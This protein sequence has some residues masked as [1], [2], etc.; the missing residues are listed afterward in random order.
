MWRY[1]LRRWRIVKNQKLHDKLTIMKKFFTIFLKAESRP[2]LNMLPK[3]CERIFGEAPGGVVILDG[4]VLKKVL[5]RQF[6]CRPKMGLAANKDKLRKLTESICSPEKM[7][8]LDMPVYNFALEDDGYSADHIVIADGRHRTYLLIFEHDVEFLPII[9][10]LAFLPK[11][12]NL[13]GYKYGYRTRVHHQKQEV[14]DVFQ[15][16]QTWHIGTTLEKE[17]IE[18]FYDMKDAQIAYSG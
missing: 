15:K 3:G 6:Q 11:F 18:S 13:Y 8:D 7:P 5:T 1:W 16:N 12:R 2:T 14:I 10:P 17:S 9:A 4:A